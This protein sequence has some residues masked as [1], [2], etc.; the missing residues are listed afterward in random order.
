MIENLLRKFSTYVIIVCFWSGI[1]IAVYQNIH[2]KTLKRFST[3]FTNPER[4]TNAAKWVMIFSETEEKLLDTIFLH[5]TDWTLFYIFYQTGKI[6]IT[7]GKDEVTD[8]SKLLN[9]G[10][11][12]GNFELDQDNWR[13]L[14]CLYAIA[15]GAEQIYELDSDLNVTN[16]SFLESN[17]LTGTA[18]YGSEYFDVEGYFVQGET[19]AD[20]PNSGSAYRVGPIRPLIKQGLVCGFRS[21]ASK[22]KTDNNN[23]PPIFLFPGVFSS[24]S[25]KNTVYRY[26]ALWALF[27]PKTNPSSL[28]EVCRNLINQ[29]LVWEIGGTVG[30]YPPNAIN[31]SQS[32]ADTEGS[33]GHRAA[34]L[35]IE[36]LLKWRCDPFNSFF[37]C[38]F[39][40]ISDLVTETGF[41]QPKNIHI[42]AVWIRDLS[43]IGYAEPV[44]VE[45]KFIT[46]STL[47]TVSKTSYT[48]KTKVSKA[49][50]IRSNHQ[51]KIKST[52]QLEK[53]VKLS[54]AVAIRSKKIK[55][56]KQLG[57][58][59]EVSKAVETRSHHQVKFKST[60]QPGK[61]M[62]HGLSQELKKLPMNR[63]LTSVVKKSQRRALTKI[64]KLAGTNSKLLPS[65]V[66]KRPVKISP[67][68]V[69]TSLSISK[70]SSIKS[71]SPV[72]KHYRKKASTKQF[73]K[74]LKNPPSLPK[75]TRLASSGRVPEHKLKTLPTMKT[76]SSL[77]RLNISKIPV[78]ALFLN[79]IN[80]VSKTN[81]IKRKPP[82]KTLQKKPSSSAPKTYSYS[83]KLKT[84]SKICPSIESKMKSTKLTLSSRVENILLLIIFNRPHYENIPSLHKT[85][86]HSFT[87]IVY[88]GS[89]LKDFNLKSAKFGFG[90]TFIEVEMLTGIYFYRCLAKVM[91]MNYSVDGYLYIGDDVLINPWRI[92]HL[93]INKIWLPTGGT[94]RMGWETMKWMHWSLP[95]GR[96]AMLRVLEE[97]KKNHTERYKTFTRNL[98]HNSKFPDGI[99]Y[100][101]SDIAYV[102]ASLKTDAIF[103]LELFSKHKVY[104]EITVHSVLGGILPLENIFNLPGAYIWKTHLKSHYA[105]FY[106]PTLFFLHPFKFGLELKSKSGLDFF[107]TRFVPFLLSDKV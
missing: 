28:R 99:L 19:T 21:K 77:L 54:K 42:M 100:G 80:V 15:N 74:A 24:Y 34:D 31:K 47:P 13:F 57:K 20:L 87:K 81:S 18:Y 39:Q 78:K 25:V 37:K 43:S 49:V 89:S 64:Q 71:K 6:T 27:S 32:A 68:L 33:K 82:L 88:C 17:E 92:K 107:C 86:S 23:A 40:L 55:S 16:A 75:H 3:S 51:V 14:C 65:I 84:M 61:K 60:K 102:P 105:S 101:G 44:R 98:A 95:Y 83:E 104:L 93:P 76:R 45:W 69:P 62:N 50:A 11:E 72:L 56:T 7:I 58:K 79:K 106:K 8:T 29:R 85:Y 26:E 59:T 12:T 38:M 5:D 41:L 53:K 103:Y 52:K 63:N 4:P 96:Q 9:F 35:L 36:F 94:T 97:L 73:P 46:Y 90:V 91:R 1:Y 30:F 10:F 70:K 2:F 22:P 66:T 48:E 67:K